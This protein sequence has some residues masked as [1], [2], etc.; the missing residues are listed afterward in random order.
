MKKNFVIIHYNTPI[1]TSCL[2]NSINKFVIDP[3]IYIFDN[4]DYLP[5]KGDMKNVIIID[6]TKGDY[7]D[8]DKWLERYKRKNISTGKNNKW[9]SAKHCY[10]IE[11]C[12]N[13]IKDNF[14]LLDS[15]VLLKKDL[16]DL[17]SENEIF[18]GEIE[19]QPSSA[20]KRVLPFMC[21]IN[22]N[23]CKKYGI[24]YF[25]E[26]YMHGLYN[27]SIVKTAD[28]YDTGAGFYLFA[29]QYN[30]KSIKLSDYIVHYGHGS[31]NKAN[32]TK[33]ITQEEWLNINKT[34]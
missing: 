12:M 24:S 27:N 17:F 19:N 10:S 5:Y 28:L 20:I 3:V 14:I 33:R 15:D 34:Q 18:V 16:S 29:K 23:M 21:Y 30:Y 9:A 13:L 32:S 4:S 11:V 8:F 1:L 7:I 6:N 22:Y 2:V 31:W 25:N 26:D